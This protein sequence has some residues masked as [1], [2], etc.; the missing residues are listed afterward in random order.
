MKKF[1]NEVFKKGRNRNIFI[2]V[3]VL[4]LTAVSLRATY[5]AF[6]TVK[7]NTIN[8][9]ITTGTLNVSF[10]N[11][12]SSINK[13]L[14]D[15]ISNEAGMK[16]SESSV[17]YIQNTG[18]MDSVFT[19]N[20]GYN[21]A[22]FASRKDYSVN[23]R[24]LPID[25]IMFAVYEHI[26]G[27][28]VLVTGPISMRDLPIYR[29]FS[30]NYLNDRYLLMVGD[31]GSIRS[32]KASKTYK[33]KT[34]L[35]DNAP[36]E[37]IHS[38]FYINLEVLAEAQN[39]KMA[40]DLSGNISDGNA[41]VANAKLIFQN[42]S[43]V[44]TTNNSGTWSLNN[45]YPG[46]YNF[47]IIYDGNTYSGNL[48]VEESYNGSNVK[49]ISMGSRTSNADVWATSV[50]YGT[51]I[52]KLIDNNNIGEYSNNVGPRS[53]NLKSTYKL[54][55][56]GVENINGITILLDTENYTFSMLIN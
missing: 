31:V 44:S 16:Q 13:V 10:A 23:D 4:A 26:N 36:A 9:I 5:A 35:S 42:G 50:N 12:S 41:N 40:Y 43:Q 49:L 37:V 15:R 1:L 48:T 29:H 33:I 52:G 51:T 17:V 19:L 28:D 45:I 46:T 25:Y 32:G 11:N 47:D 6:F 30:N 55:A 56:G 22:D 3:C 39:A 27:E 54:T 20:V 8:Q 34:W 7:T 21:L 18:N 38:Y 14:L 24:L 2:L 53:F